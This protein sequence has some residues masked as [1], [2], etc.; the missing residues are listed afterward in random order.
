MRYALCWHR[1]T[2]LTVTTWRSNTLSY[3]IAVMLLLLL[4]KLCCYVLIVIIVEGAHPI[5]LGNLRVLR[6]SLI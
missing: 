6:W 2:N 4:F 1:A 5:G 3:S